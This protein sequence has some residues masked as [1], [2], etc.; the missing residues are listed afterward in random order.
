MSSGRVCTLLSF[1]DSMGSVRVRGVNRTARAEG[2]SANRRVVGRKAHGASPV[3][4][5]PRVS[6]RADEPDAGHSGIVRNLRLVRST[7]ANVL[8]RPPVTVFGEADRSGTA[9]RLRPAFR[10]LTAILLWT[11]RFA[12]LA[13]L[14]IASSQAEHGAPRSFNPNAFPM[15]GRLWRL[16]RVRGV[17]VGCPARA[18]VRGAAARLIRIE[19]ASARIMPL[20]RAR[21]LPPRRGSSASRSPSPSRLKP[22][23]DSMMAAP[24]NRNAHHAPLVKYL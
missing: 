1:C 8:G 15:P 17:C 10:S 12:F 19:K 20:L 23:T 11:A 18:D 16:S 5:A 14:A 21:Q 9:R 6:R 2:V 7:I 3:V 4:G 22:S 13:V 24:G